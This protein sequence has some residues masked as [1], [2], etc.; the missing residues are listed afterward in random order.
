L[1]DQQTAERPESERPDPATPGA[2]SSS[3]GSGLFGRGLLYVVVWSLQLLA[4]TI[5][6][7]IL[8][9]L[10]GPS[11]FGELASA[12][13]LFQVLSV[14]ALLGLD[15]VVVLLRAQDGDIRG[16]RGLVSVAMVIAFAVT[17]LA[18]GT[19][20][21]WGPG[22]GFH[23]DSMIVTLVILWTGP[24]AA[25]QVMLALLVAEDR[26]RTFSIVSVISAVGGSVVGLLLLVL[27]PG[28]T[29]VTYA[30]GGVVCQ[31][32][33]MAVGIVVTRPRIAGLW[34]WSLAGRSIRLGLPLAFGGLA[35]FVLNAGDRIVIQRDL[36]SAEV[37]RY[38]V[39][40]VIGSAVILL[41]GFTNSAWA[42]HFA[43]LTR[44]TT[45]FALAMHS[46]D[47]LY[48]LLMPIVLAVTLASPLALR[49]LAPASFRPN[50]LTLVVFVV[51]LSAFPVAQAGAT[52]RLL[53]LRRRGKTIG[54]L[55]A[56]SAVVNIGVN[57]LLVPVMGILGSAV[58]TFVSCVLL[59]WLQLRALRGPRRDRVA[60]GG[61]R[62]EWHGPSR[63]L[64]LAIVVT[65]AAA[66]ASILLPQT[67][68]WNLIRA[69]AALAC[70]PWFL[71][72]LRSARDA[73]PGEGG[74]EDDDEDDDDAV[75]EAGAGAVSEPFAAPEAGVVPEPAPQPVAAAA[76][77]PLTAD[78]P[79]AFGPDRTDRTAESAEETS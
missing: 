68:V 73:G 70:V 49:I 77:S 78:A 8:A 19:S 34:N 65:V 16:A 17:A 30:W 23:A 46:R 4:S 71:V 32:L 20:P 63:R 74:L 53:L 62:P 67:V 24:S 54:V 2:A 7:P 56:I 43:R 52:D 55:A 28:S 15:Q 36:G 40:Y 58:A 11:E 12:L 27:I 6:S 50:D 47:M 38:Q 29:A 39:A 48:R 1:H 60:Q 44:E 76:D 72:R 75:A 10:L 61:A 42:P 51:A 22:L 18:L 64:A 41:L 45:R 26:L 33:A 9:H 59:S 3:S 21:L 37:G 25:V 5:V 79:R 69:A 35:Y 31:F 57:L 66:A 13:A 14:A